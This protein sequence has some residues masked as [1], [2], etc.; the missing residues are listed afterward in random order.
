MRI[1][2]FLVWPEKIS[3]GFNRNLWTPSEVE[4]R[5]RR[6]T[7]GSI[8]L[9]GE[10]Y[11]SPIFDHAFPDI[12]LGVNCALFM[13]SDFQKRLKFKDRSKMASIFD[14]GCNISAQKHIQGAPLLLSSII[15]NCHISKKEWGWFYPFYIKAYAAQHM[16][17]SLKEFMDPQEQIQHAA[18]NLFRKLLNQRLWPHKSSFSSFL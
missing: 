15:V 6:R 16:A 14:R 13:N 17:N 7:D 5:P 10:R 9:T 12:L 2:S 4:L 3:N 8:R 18:L 1:W 11:K